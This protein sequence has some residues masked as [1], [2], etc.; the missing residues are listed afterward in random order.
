MANEKSFND[1]Q[2]WLLTKVGTDGSVSWNLPVVF[3]GEGPDTI[4]AVRELPDGRIVLIGTMRTG[5]PDVGETKM[6]L[7][8]VNQDGKLLK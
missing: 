5:K 1:N 3:G 7:L 8:K 4:G 6:T 2:N